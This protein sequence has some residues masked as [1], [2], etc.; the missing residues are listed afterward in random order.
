MK[1]FALTVGTLWLREMVRFYRQPSRV[2]GAIAS[3]LLF[4]L[5]IGSGIGSSFKSSGV[6]GEQGYLAYFYPGTLLLIVFFTAV[7]STISIIEDRREGF[8][9]SVLIAPVSRTAIVLGKIL[10]GSALSVIQAGLFLV[11]LPW[12]G[13]EVASHVWIPFFLILFLNAFV[14]TSLGFLVAWQFH[15][16]QG[17]H[18]VM[19]LFLMPMWIL[20]GALFPQE[21]AS[22]WVSWIM[23]VNPLTYGLTA[24]RSL[25]FD[26]QGLD[27]MSVVITCVVGVFLFMLASWMVRPSAKDVR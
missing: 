8:L 19:N 21:G 23:K 20:S 18:A 13:I 3:P 15:S 9:Q 6:G 24:L 12:A 26:P 14:L 22:Q 4:W 5:L 1:T 7:F 10:G 27:G 25:L 17:F 16:I 2:L 11:L